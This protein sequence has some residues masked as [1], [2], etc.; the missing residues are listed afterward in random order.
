MAPSPHRIGSP[1][2]VARQTDHLLC[3]HPTGPEAT[4]G[5]RLCLLGPVKAKSSRLRAQCCCSTGS[6][7]ALR[8]Q[9]PVGRWSVTTHS[10]LVKDR[11]KPAITD[12]ENGAVVP[13]RGPSRDK[14][15]ARVAAV[16]SAGIAVMSAALLNNAPCGLKRPHHLLL[17]VAGKRRAVGD[18]GHGGCVL[19]GRNCRPGLPRL[20]MTIV[21]HALNDRRWLPQAP[22]RSWDRPSGPSLSSGTASQKRQQPHC[23]LFVADAGRAAVSPEIAMTASLAGRCGRKKAGG[24]DYGLPSARCLCFHKVMPSARLNDSTKKIGRPATGKGAP[25]VVRLQPK[26]LAAIDA[27]IE[28]HPD[29][30]SRPEAIRRLAEMGL[31]G[32]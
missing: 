31:K 10:T 15:E 32:Q 4:V 27:W 25:I 23:S 16:E 26:Q 5:R 28:H 14:P 22:A 13:G 9:A 20:G 21:G 19:R 3:A 1:N 30:L 29:K 12:N 8:G 2:G 6:G 17:K 11:L 18:A 7:T 24:G